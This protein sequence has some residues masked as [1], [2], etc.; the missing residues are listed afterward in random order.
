MIII[1]LFIFLV[2]P[3]SASEIDINY[4]WYKYNDSSYMSLDESKNISGYIDYSDYIIDEYFDIKT[5]E[6]IEGRFIYIYN[7]TGKPIKSIENI[8]IYYNGDKIDY[9]ATCQYADLKSMS[10]KGFIMIDM[11]S[12]KYLKDIEVEM[13]YDGGDVLISFSDTGFLFDTTLAQEKINQSGKYK[14]NHIKNHQ[15]I[16]YKTYYNRIDGTY[17]KES[18]EDYI[19]KDYDDY[20]VNYFFYQKKINQENIQIKDIIDTNYTFLR[21][22]G[23][24]DLNKNGNYELKIIFVECEKDIE[25]IVDIKKDE[26]LTKKLEELNNSLEE[27]NKELENVKNEVNNKNIKVEELNKVLEENKIKIKE[28]EEQLK[29]KDIT[30][31]EYENKLKELNNNLEEKNKKLE[32]VKNEVNDKNIKIEELN[33]IIEADKIKI[34][35][36]EKQNKKIKKEINNKNKAIK[37]LNKKLKELEEQNKKLKKEIE[38]QNKTIIKNKG[39]ID[40]LNKQIK[41]LKKQIKEINNQIKKYE[42]EK[43]KSEEK[44]KLLE[45]ENNNL[46]NELEINKKIYEK[47]K[48]NHKKIVNIKNK[49]FNELN[50]YKKTID[51]LD[52]KYNNDK[53]YYER[54]IKKLKYVIDEKNNDYWNIKK[55]SIFVGFITN[56]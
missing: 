38:K 6:K 23:N 3:V 2:L 25:V 12:N 51:Y 18:Y 5:Y 47:N 45:D 42:K 34:K 22:E 40:E 31:E 48:N 52:S 49:C 17:A 28:L 35:E 55:S 26:E 20:K 46:K 37:E 27:K 39:K 32:N 30:I 14:F 15:E 43:I 7:K 19:Y 56:H 16:K 29:N 54:Y 10:S 21:Y 36:L 50:E 53:E 44:M 11:R 13:N 8:N 4:K 9:K 1:F 24:I 33:K 41:E